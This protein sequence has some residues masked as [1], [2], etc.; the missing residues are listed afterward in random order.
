MNNNEEYRNGRYDEADDNQ[1]A[2]A[3]GI[4][5]II[6]VCLL[7]VGVVGLLMGWI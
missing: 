3:T 4:L 2:M 5:L 1:D 6:P 7:I